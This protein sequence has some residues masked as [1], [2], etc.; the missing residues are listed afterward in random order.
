MQ[1]RPQIILKSNLIMPILATEAK[2]NEI[3][4][5]LD[6]ITSN[7]S[8]NGLFLLLVSYIESMQ[9]EIIKHYLKY[10]PEKISG[11]S[12]EV[13]KAV[14]IESEDFY[15]LERI[16]ADYIDKM[17]YWRLSA[18][19]FDVL[20]IKE[21]ENEKGI[22]KIKKRRNDLIHKNLIIDFKHK[23]IG[24]DSINITF[25]NDCIKEY[26]NYLS[27]LKST[28]SL[29]FN[30]FS[31]INALENLWH[32]TFTTPL[33][34]NFSDYWHLDIENDTIIGCKHPEIEDCLSS[35]EMFMLE[36]WRSQVCGSKVSFINMSSIGNH[37]Q[38]C[39][40]LFLKLSNDLFLYD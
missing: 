24:Q 35:S 38:N 25:L 1:K 36:I 14:L 27:E 15:F 16:V 33:C 31:K 6:H 12:I 2:I 7:V 30:K 10:R 13:E 9:K 17:P 40:Y 5:E 34:S 3:K 4:K 29:T 22:Q 19:F 20:G 28:I 11:S 39:L 8:L 18:L 21:P 23:K 26:E 32:Y 37:Y